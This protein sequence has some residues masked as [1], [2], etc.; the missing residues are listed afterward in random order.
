MPLQ[1]Q[2]IESS[3]I[4][5]RIVN[6]DSELWQTRYGSIL[7]VLVTDPNVVTLLAVVPN[8]VVVEA[9]FVR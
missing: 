6:S 1:Q 3:N 8:Y 5:V 2:G 9:E 7:V 4:R